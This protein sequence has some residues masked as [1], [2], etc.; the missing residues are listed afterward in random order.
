MNKK[1][2]WLMVQL[3]LLPNAYWLDFFNL[4]KHLS[5]L[6]PDFKR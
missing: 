6:N 3:Y 2:N 1:N 5:D 4:E